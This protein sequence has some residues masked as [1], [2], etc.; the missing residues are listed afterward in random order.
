VD[1]LNVAEGARVELDRVL[2]LGDGDKVTVGTP[3][4]EGARVVATA[5]AEG[6]GPKT[7]VLKFKAK[8]RYRRK[9]GHRQA[10]TRLSIDKIVGPKAATR[11]PAAK[12]SR[13]DEE[14]SESGA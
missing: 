4:V 1:R 13:G 5:A 8:V 2:V 7:I 10:Y 6:R 14:V 9:T 12:A 11:K 3:T